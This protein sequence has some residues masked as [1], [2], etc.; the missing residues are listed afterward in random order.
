MLDYIHTPPLIQSL[1]LLEALR[2]FQQLRVIG[3]TVASHWVPTLGRV[4]AGIGHERC[5]QPRVDVFTGATP[6]ST[7]HNVDKPFVADAVDERVQEAQRFLV[8]RETGAVQ[9]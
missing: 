6:R 2:Q 4:P 7:V 8:C 5:L 1:D 3:S 9:E